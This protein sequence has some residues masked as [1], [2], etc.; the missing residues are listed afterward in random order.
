MAVNA[1]SVTAPT[2]QVTGQSMNVTDITTIHY[3]ALGSAA[4]QRGAVSAVASR[5]SGLL[6]SGRRGRPQ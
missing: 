6:A 3:A 5:L 2:G 4:W 1:E